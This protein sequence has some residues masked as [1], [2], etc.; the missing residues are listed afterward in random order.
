MLVNL[1]PQN[2][3]PHE[4]PAFSHLIKYRVHGSGSPHLLQDPRFFI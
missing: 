1:T 4:T 2:P 3:S